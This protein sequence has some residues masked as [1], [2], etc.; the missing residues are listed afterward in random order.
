MGNAY[1]H[2]GAKKRLPKQRKEVAG[3]EYQ[4]E[5]QKPDAVLRLRNVHRKAYYRP[6]NS[7]YLEH[8]LSQRTGDGP[9]THL[10]S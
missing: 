10:Q 6:D 3:A 8:P 5:R 1:K 7:R 9:S 4:I 2:G